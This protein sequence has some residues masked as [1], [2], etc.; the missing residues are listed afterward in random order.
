MTATV[1]TSKDVKVVMADTSKEVDVIIGVLGDKEKNKGYIETEVP[2]CKT[3]GAA[4][5]QV[6]N[7]AKSGK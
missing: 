1:S 6:V 3:L 4:A 5:L 2:R 7:D